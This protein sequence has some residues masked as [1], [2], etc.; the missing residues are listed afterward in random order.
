MIGKFEVTKSGHDTFMFNLRADNGLV[1]LSS[2]T[3]GDKPGVMQGIESV[4]R[5][6]PIDSRFE[7][8]SSA[9]GEPYFNLKTASGHIVGHSQM[10]SSTSAME[11]G[12]A[13]VIRNA[14]NAVLVDMAPDQRRAT[15][16]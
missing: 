4:R 8:L 11:N 14:P 15:L 12:I 9:S 1:I 2:E 16:R 13:S 6:A 10:Y 3:Y 7:R 5:N